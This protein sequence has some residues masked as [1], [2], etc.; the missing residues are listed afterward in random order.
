LPV[1]HGHPPAF[2]TCWCTVLTLEATIILVSTKSTGGSK[3]VHILSHRPRRGRHC[4]V[5][6]RG[7]NA[8]LQGTHYPMAPEPWKLPVPFREELHNDTG[9]AVLGDFTKLLPNSARL[10]GRIQLWPG[11]SK[12]LMNWEVYS[13]AKLPLDFTH[14]SSTLTLQLQSNPHAPQMFGCATVTIN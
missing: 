7:Q 4:R 11:R 9:A 12:V 6:D 1:T 14:Q 10:L 5:V 2:N 3:R 8:L 13:C